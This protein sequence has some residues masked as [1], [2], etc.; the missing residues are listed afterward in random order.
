MHV[1]GTRPAG[2]T[3]NGVLIECGDSRLAGGESGVIHVVPPT[4][5][6][7]R[8]TRLVK[9]VVIE[10]ADGSGV[11]VVNPVERT[12][13]IVA[14]HVVQELRVIGRAL[15]VGVNAVAGTSGIARLHRVVHHVGVACIAHVQGVHRA[16]TV[17]HA[18]VVEHLGAIARAGLGVIRAVD[19]E[20]RHACPT[21]VVA[22]HRAIVRVVNV[23]GVTTGRGDAGARGA[24]H[25][26][27]AR[28]YQRS[29]NVVQIHAV[30]VPLG[31]RVASELVA[32]G[33]G[34]IG[35]GR[36]V[37]TDAVVSAGDRVV[38]D[39]V[40]IAIVTGGTVGGCR[41]SENADHFVVGGGGRYLDHAIADLVII[42]GVGE[43]HALS[44][45]GACRADGEIFENEVIRTVERDRGTVRRGGGVGQDTRGGVT[46]SA[47]KRDGIRRA[48]AGDGR[49]GDLFVV[50]TGKYTERHRTGH[51]A[52]GQRGHSGGETGVIATTANGVTTAQL[53]KG[54]WSKVQ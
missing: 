14:D 40:V 35:G 50:G 52:G 42:R 27:V 23:I 2:I 22:D 48:R 36:T 8:D 16:R 49:Y 30:V 1:G 9:H 12:R 17:R 31:Q 43:Q 19:V 26:I 25:R 7:R 15:S 46:G 4:V 3:D 21:V 5:L 45:G 33:R 41:A 10:G 44:V 24:L 28:H 51:T 54:G 34:V 38:L 18:H 53:R 32:H 39:Q 20:R 47:V 29:A 11:V 13:A 37:P 6:R